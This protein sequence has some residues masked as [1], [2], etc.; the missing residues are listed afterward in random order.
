VVPRLADAPVDRRDVAVVL[1]DALVVPHAL[2]AHGREVEAR[3][4]DHLA[5]GPDAAHVAP[6]RRRATSSRKRPGG[7]AQH[8]GVGDLGR[9]DDEEEQLAAVHARGQA[10]EL[11]RAQVVVVSG[12]GG[13]VFEAD[14]GVLVPAVGVELDAVLD[15]PDVGPGVVAAGLKH[16]VKDLAALDLAQH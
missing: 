5:G 2:R 16:R 4:V 7:P 13:Q 14:A 1:A 12:L 3:R 10:G 8:L 6:P 11:V 15:E 9:V